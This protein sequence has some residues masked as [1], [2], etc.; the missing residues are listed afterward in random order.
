MPLAYSYLRF[1]SPA[2]ATT[3]SIR[4]QTEAREKWLEGHP[5]IELDGSLRMTDAG[6]SGFRRKNW[7]TYALAQFVAHVKSGRVEPGSFLLVENLDRLSRE[8][9]GEA[10]EL[11]LSIVNK[12]VAVVQL[13]P[14][15][16]EFRRPVDM[17]SLMFAIVELS[18]GH[19]ESAM[20]SERVGKAWA[21]KQREAGERIVTRRLPGWVRLAGGKLVL[22]RERAALVRRIYRMAIEGAGGMTIAKRLNAEGVPV[23]GRAKVKGR[24]VAWSNVGVRFILTTRAVLGEYAPYRTDRHRETGG[25]VPNYYPAVVD[26]RTYYAAQAA[27][28]TRAAVGRGRRG[29][30][31]NLFAGLLHDARD[32]GPVTYR[33]QQ[34]HAVLVPTNATQGRGKWASFPAEQFEEAFL[35]EFAELNAADIEGDGREAAKK[36]REKSGRKEELEALIRAWEAK[37]GNLSIIDRVAAN[38]E[39]FTAEHKQVCKDLADAQREAASPLSEAVGGLKTLAELLARD[40]SDEMR[41]KVRGALRQCIESVHCLFL[42]TMTTRLAAVRVQFRESD[43]HRDYLIAVT[44]QRAGG[45]RGPVLSPPRSFKEAALPGRFDLRDPKHAA[46]LEK[47]LSAVGAKAG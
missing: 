6:R 23:L 29:K 25:A 2:Q 8:D 33:H 14:A 5:G 36:V 43:E 9:A 16:M 24:A 39:K 46:A 42:G 31:V 32:G 44:Y 4:R 22:D 3:D 27:M 11:F 26:E 13:S 47:L 7:D 19:S 41:L 17:M 12:G 37:M 18:R 38:L 35:R 40:N 21:R 1:S 15:V 45:R 28:K 20:K 10:T 30:H 34:P